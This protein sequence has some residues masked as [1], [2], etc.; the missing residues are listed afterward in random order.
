MK[1]SKDSSTQLITDTSYQEVF[2]SE[3]VPAT[4]IVSVETEQETKHELPLD[5][6]DTNYGVLE[7]NKETET[8]PA[9]DSNLKARFSGW[10]A[11]FKISNSKK[12]TPIGRPYV[13]PTEEKT[14]DS[15]RATQAGFPMESLS[16]AGHSLLDST[17]WIGR[18]L[19]ETGGKIASALPDRQQTAALLA[20]TSQSLVSAG[21]KVGES[22]RSIRLPSAR[23][24]DP[25]PPSHSAVSS[26][27][28]GTGAS[29][30]VPAEGVF[31]ISL[32]GVCTRESERGGVPQLVIA[33]VHTLYSTGLETEG[34][35]REDGSRTKQDQ[36]MKHFNDDASPLLPEGC[37]AHDVAGLLKRFLRDLPEPLMTFELYSCVTSAGAPGGFPA[38]VR[39]ALLTLPPAPFATLRLVLGLA[40]AVAQQHYFNKMDAQNLGR[41]LAPVL[42]W[43]EPPNKVETYSESN[44]LEFMRKITEDI[45]AIA[46]VIEH[47]IEC[48][49]VIF[50]TPMYEEAILQ[51]R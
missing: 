7:N 33:C 11:K 36:L 5:F 4:S 46:V 8:S 21:V 15:T 35:F 37:S 27:H 22:L 45:P 42:I 48:Y 10:T 19:G 14:V 20:A 50:N 29:E 16:A 18:G 6:I 49:D 51:Q 2:D 23:N 26:A 28:L 24:L 39:E 30:K 41:V 9:L 1:I 13:R 47:L 40:A 38:L 44:E 31:G 12:E 25:M 32:Q 3:E 43:P 34:L 17:S